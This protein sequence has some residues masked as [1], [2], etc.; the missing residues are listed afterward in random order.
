MKAPVLLAEFLKIKLWLL[1]WWNSCHFDDLI[2]TSGWLHK[3]RWIGN[4]ARTG[5]MN[6]DFQF[7]NTRREV[8]LRDQCINRKNET[9]MH[10]KTKFVV[11]QTEFNGLRQSTNNMLWARQIT[12]RFHERNLIYGKDKWLLA[13]ESGFFS[14]PCLCLQVVS[15]ELNSLVP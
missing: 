4:V 9:I 7:G 13:S 12:F 3:G 5:E 11:G 14:I 1:K 8:C 6:K 2:F 15:F 10:H